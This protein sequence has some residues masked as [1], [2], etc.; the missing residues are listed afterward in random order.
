MKDLRVALAQMTPRLGDVARNLD[1][2]MRAL[3]RAARERVDLV[4]FPELSLTGYLLRDQVPDVAESPDG[5][6]LRKL[7]RACRSIDAVVGF[8]EEVPGYRFCNSAAYLAGGK[9]VHVQRK[10][11]LPTYGM[12]DEGR[13]FAPGETLRAFDT[14]FGRAGIL[15]CE[16]AWHTTSAWLLAQDGAEILFVLSS[17]PTRG[18][19]AKRGVTSVRVWHE[20]LTVTAQFQTAWIVYVNRVG[21]EDGLGFGGGSAVIDPF[22]RT[23]LELSPLEEE[24]GVLDLRGETVR[25]ARTAYPLLRDDN[26]DFVHRELGRL[27]A[28]RYDLPEDEAADAGRRD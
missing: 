25:R 4:V 26:L 14:G 5:P 8:V 15:I 13:D 27:R 23:D 24:W 9:V 21:F 7:A 11:Y 20:L 10:V 19:R 3:R 17:A 1:L 18:A 2:H 22:G 28:R 6:A 12:F 16:D